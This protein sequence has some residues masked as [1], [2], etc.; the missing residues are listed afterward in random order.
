M[1]L[2]QQSIDMRRPERFG[3]HDQASNAQEWMKLR[4][5]HPYGPTKQHVLPPGLTGQTWSAGA[6]HSSHRT[7]VGEITHEAFTQP[8]S[9]R[10][11]QWRL[12]T[13]RL[14][15]LSLAHGWRL[16]ITIWPFDETIAF[17]TVF[18]SYPTGRNHWQCTRRSDEH[19]VESAIQASLGAGHAARISSGLLFRLKADALIE[20][21][22]PETAQ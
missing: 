3:P 7:P 10:E 21:R 18:L 16:I 15:V 11:H 20:T 22:A 14:Q 1:G 8:E 9:H 2:L 12:Q 6:D 17:I 19:D 13:Y 4:F 5:R